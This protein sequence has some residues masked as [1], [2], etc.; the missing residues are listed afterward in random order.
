MATWDPNLIFFGYI[1]IAAISCVIC[2]RIT[3][4][5]PQQ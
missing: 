5:L 1:V 2:E 4:H 3:N